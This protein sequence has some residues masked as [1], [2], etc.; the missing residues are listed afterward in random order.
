MSKSYGLKILNPNRGSPCTTRLF[1]FP[2]GGAGPEIFAGWA[3]DLPAQIEVIGIHIPGRGTRLNEAPF[4]RMAPLADAVRAALSGRLDKPFAF[5]GHSLGALLAF[6]VAHRLAES[7][8]GVM[9][10]KLIVSGLGAPHLPQSDPP[11]HS[12]PTEAFIDRLRELAGTPEQVLQHEELME[13]TLPALRADFAVCETYQYTER[14]PLPCPIT[15]FGGDNDPEVALEDIAEWG[16][17]TTA[18][19]AIKTFAGG[20][21][22]IHAARDAVLNVIADELRGTFPSRCG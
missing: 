19:F 21:F 20:H 14:P 12:L 7:G 11:A 13:I 10:A 8:G 16:D 15:A 2:Y 5:F 18:A 6:E 4:T 9:P 1:C 3:D 22:F 17:H